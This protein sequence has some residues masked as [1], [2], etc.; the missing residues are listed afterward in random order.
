MGLS[1]PD[2]PR[3]GPHLQQRGNHA[4]PQP[5]NDLCHGRKLIKEAF[6]SNRLPEHRTKSILELMWLA[7]NDKVLI[8]LTVVAIISLAV[9]L[10]Q[11]L[12]EQH[13]PGRSGTQWIEGV[14][15]MV[16]VVLVVVAGAVNDYQKEQQF[17]R[18]NKKKEDRTVTAIR[19][20]K[21]VQI[22]VHDIEVGEVLDVKS[23]DSIPADGI[24][25][26]GFHIVCDESSITGE[27]E[28]VKK[29][30][31]ADVKKML[32]SGHPSE[33]MDP[34]L[35]SGSKV[36]E[37]IGTYLVTGIGVHSIY[38]RLRMGLTDRVA[39]TPLQKKLSGV[40]DSIA[41]GG[42]TAAVVL[43][44]VLVA[45]LVAQLPG[46]SIAPADALQAFLRIFI[47][48]LAVVV[49]AVPEG[50][51]LAVTLSL[52]T[53]VMRMLKDNNL[54]RV[55]AACEVMGGATTVCC[56]K[57]GTI[58]LNKMTV[59]VGLIGEKLRFADGSKYPGRGYPVGSSTSSL[60]YDTHSQEANH[61]TPESTILPGENLSGA[62]CPESRELLLHSFAVNST[63]FESEEVDGHAYVGS[64]TESALL[65]FAESRI[66]MESVDRLR[67]S[68]EIVEIIPF[69]SSRKFM[70]TIVKLSGSICR[71]YIKG[72]PELL[73]G[74]S[75]Y[76]VTN[77]N[78][79]LATNPMSDARRG[80]LSSTISD[81]AAQS[82]RTLGLAY[83]DFASWPPVSAQ[84][85]AS[86]S[87]GISFDGILSSLTFVAIL[88]IRDP[89]RPG[90]GEAV[91]LCQ[92][93]GVTVR[94]VTGDNVTTATAIA[95]ECGIL[96]EQGLVLEGSQFRKLSATELDST[97]L[98][99]QVLA[100]STPEDKKLLVQALKRIG[101]TVAV[102]GDGT[103]DGPALRAA[104]VGFSM[105]LS[106]TEVAKEASSIVLMDDNFASIVKSIE[107]GRS[108]GDAIK[109]FLCFQLTA[110]ISAVA[111]TFVSAI[112]DS[113][114]ESLLTPVQLLWMNLIMDTFAALALATD[115][116]Q[117]NILDRRPDRKSD[118]LISTTSWKMI[119]GQAI[120][121]TT[122]SLGL[123]FAGGPL[124]GYHTPDERLSLET[125]AFNT[126]VWMQVFNLYNNRRLDNK[127]NIFENIGR[128]WY[129]INI[130]VIIMVGQ[131]LI[132]CFG[133]S[134]L[135]A[136]PLSPLEWAISLG[137]G[138]M[139]L[140]VGVLIRLVPDNFFWKIF[141]TISGMNR[142]PEQDAASSRAPSFTWNEAIENVRLELISFRESR[143]SRLRRLRLRLVRI[144]SVKSMLAAALSA[145]PRAWL[146][147]READIEEG[148]RP[149]DGERQ[150][151]LHHREDSPSSA[152][153]D[154]SSPPFAPAAV[155]AGI[156]AG[157]VGGWAP[158]RAG[159][160]EP[161]SGEA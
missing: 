26:S 97:V 118:P 135:S 126:F 123:Y 1:V 38:G 70:A 99:L 81:Y 8:L 12:A 108:V 3:Q 159:V 32:D 5:P 127:L 142:Y 104:D 76:I 158:A 13:R 153:R 161:A 150:P 136:V 46:S 89:L 124:L 115:P 132:I 25:I 21:A 152:C 78:S 100:R 57:T 36:S 139:T 113:H 62:L 61:D 156:V 42:L 144:D 86:Y 55:L 34:F 96:T 87:D 33:H 83:R 18:L 121:Q 29:T 143:S 47:V 27:S 44:V 51:P 54:V 11:T 63:A 111:I 71:M 133:G 31:A 116:P 10:Y 95:A 15:I 66:G 134:A 114:E 119:I 69:D 92:H 30:D 88:G 138:F 105:G 146:G 17:A 80:V 59:V 14:T 131:V 160:E 149:G 49:L 154:P 68:V 77:G 4:T 67:E 140:P 82:L 43:F 120:Y 72:A 90:V 60:V 65:A 19:S 56:D 106:G 7:F 157:S 2:Q 35:I 130:N 52:A 110:N 147:A 155:M 28:Q 93:A 98:R 128:N 125:L 75:S 50:L 117:P 103:N 145:L 91:A 73:L 9:G 85:V 6:G 53:T 102:T 112:S 74:S 101:E 37:G 79:S 129:F 39:T 151:L 148:A 48:S 137:L 20:G 94:M 64:A 24:L 45:K 107:W 141:A 41:I 122:V 23:G 109:K 40:A 16:A 58:T 84:G 22:S